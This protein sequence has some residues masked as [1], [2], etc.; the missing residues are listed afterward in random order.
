MDD[1]QFTW[2][3]AKVAAN[4]SKHGVSFEARRPS[5]GILWPR[6]CLTPPTTSRNNAHSSSGIRQ[7][8]ASFW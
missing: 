3:P 7:E 6:Y 2:D 8:D 1:L 5:F 4:L